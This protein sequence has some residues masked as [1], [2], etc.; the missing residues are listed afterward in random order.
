MQKALNDRNWDVIISD[1]ALPNFSGLDALFLLQA[2]RLDIP[3][4]IVSGAIG[5]DSAVAAMKAGAHDYIMKNN[6]KRLTPAI[7][8]EIKE[9][10][11]RIKRVEAEQKLQISENR[12]RLLIE[13]ASDGIFVTDKDGKFVD[14]NR[15]A[16]RLSGYNK[17]EI[18]NL[19]LMDMIPAGTAK[20][21][22]LDMK[23][24]A[25]GKTIVRERYLKRKC[26]SQLPVEVSAKQLS[27]GSIQAI[28]RDITKRK[29]AEHELEKS[30][31]EK[32]L[33]LKEIHHRVKN[34][35]QVISS[36]FNLQA[37]QTDDEQ[38]K[39]LFRESQMRIR[40]IALIHEWLYQS[41]NMAWI[42]FD[43]Y[44]TSLTSHLFRLYDINPQRIL[45]NIVVRNAV[46]PIDT[47]VPC[48]LIINE[49]ITN[50]LKH[51]FPDDSTGSINIS[52]K[53]V[54]SKDKRKI[55]LRFYELAVRDDGM[56]LSD[57]PNITGMQSLGMRVSDCL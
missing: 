50:S 46:L 42:D 47:A 39:R 13:Q 16:C 57:D 9:A 4:I 55:G 1:Y 29:K 12:Y 45:T 11:E 30:L 14:V 36:L 6:L 48:G 34:N 19:N 38:A 51:A 10:Q 17:S 31:R 56:G 44:I 49:L 22:L 15:Q 5:E 27:D 21:I 8:R 35:M 53:S 7:D 41:K 20:R 54:R 26:G 24:V 37:R 43:N 52:F 3:F 2:G 18:L 33:L 23:A 32:D 28:V 25:S 40:S